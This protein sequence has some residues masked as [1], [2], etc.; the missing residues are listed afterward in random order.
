ME[1]DLP[2]GASQSRSLDGVRLAVAVPLY[3]EE[4]TVVELY[5]RLSSVLDTVGGG[6]HEMIFVD[7][8]SGD[9]TVS[10][11]ESVALNDPRVAVVLLSRNFG[12]Q[13]AITAALDHVNGDAVVVMDGDLQD[14][15]E[16][17]PRFVALFREGFD[18]V[19]ARRV[20]RKEPWWLRLG[21]FLFYRVLARLAEV[22]LPVD[23]GDFGL[24]SRRVVHA[25]R[26]APEHQRYL[27]GLR[28]WVGFRQIGID[29][30]RE[31]R[32]SGR[33]KYNTGR[34]LKL[35]V[36]GI[37]AF[38]IVPLRAA[39]V[40]GA[41]SVGLASL[42]ALYALYARFFMDQSPRGFTALLLV[43]WWFAGMHLVFLGVIGEYVGRI[44]EEAKARPLYIVDKV[45]GAHRDN[46]HRP[47]RTER[48][49]ENLVAP[50]DG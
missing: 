50:R 18:V 33:S 7:D 38:S 19:Y 11:L 32:H 36:D 28:T 5:R 4:E 13:A 43:V 12:H 47:P 14:A 31:V 30:E 42:F 17:I 8:G 45:I 3:N 10:L 24:M 1:H 44:Y 25:I 21:Y 20:R 22:Q 39:V 46:K 15:P 6:P 40:I 2:E 35:A 27:R 48:P 23:A 16:A 29:V 34:L 26:R 41:V 37:F 49:G 9:R